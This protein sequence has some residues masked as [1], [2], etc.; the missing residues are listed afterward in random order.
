MYFKPILSGS[1][2]LC[3]QYPQ[4]EDFCEDYSWY[5]SNYEDIH[6]K[7]LDDEFVFSLGI[8][9]YVARKEK[10]IKQDKAD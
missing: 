4:D 7:F 1:K 10:S 2:E 6:K 8:Q 3:E 9:I 5:N